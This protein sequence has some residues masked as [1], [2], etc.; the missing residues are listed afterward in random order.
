MTDLSPTHLRHETRHLL[1]L[2]APVI[3]S[4]F[5]LNALALISTAVIGR[6]GETQLAA[7]A[8]A[9]ATYYLG[10]IV[11][12]GVMLSVGPRVAAAHG[13]ADPRG[14]ARTTRAG[15]LLA[16]LLAAL[17]LPLAY[18]AAQLIG[19]HAP[20]GIRGDLAATY[21]RLYALGMPATLIFS[22]L[23]G[24]LEGT[25]Q[26]RPV[27][28][29]ALSAVALAAALSPALAFGWGPLPTLGVAGAALATVS[30]SW[31][32]AGALAW[33]ARRRLPRQPVPRAEVLNELRALLRLGWPIGLTLGAEGGLFT[34][35]SL[36]MARFGPQ[37]LAAHNVALQ[38]ITAVFMVPLGLATATGIR[39]AQH[40]GAGDLRRSRQAGLLGMALAVLIML[41]VSLT[42]IFSPNAV[43]GVF[44]NVNDP[45]NTAVVRGAASLLLI[46]TLFQAFDGLQVTANS[47]LRGLQDTR[48][49]L[50]ISLAAYWLI[51]LGSGS[52]LAFGLHLGPRG[53][54]FGLTAGLCFA[55][56]TL[57]ARFLRRTHP[58]R[59]RAA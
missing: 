22:A 16:A 50:L 46:A 7:V 34:V 51:G 31:F 33:V 44:L 12:V 19:P 17:F 57:L 10:F 29:V 14:V 21:L 56:A 54:W 24:A 37:A 41:T 55:G 8:Y 52:L 13:A 5:S 26:P 1:R 27:T 20:G 42:Y 39:V 32:S 2:A 43:I 28:A 25:G 47:A 49:P 6:L 15:L 45:A 23:R 36:L 59:A 48:W 9:S 3:V 35:T 30:A 38:V 58:D 53:L 40:A 11:L 4:Q 18:L